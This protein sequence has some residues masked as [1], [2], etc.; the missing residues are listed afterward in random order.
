MLLTRLVFALSITALLSVC[1]AYRILGVFPFN[2]KSH[3]IVFEALMKGLAKR[4]HQVDVISHF[5]LKR[6][7]KNYNDII[8]LDGSMESL[9]NNYTIE[10]VS[11]FSSLLADVGIIAAEYGNRLCHFMGFEE[12]QKLIKNPPTD[13]PYDLVVTEVFGA[14]CYIGFGHVF[15]VPVV[16]ISSAIEYP[17][18]SS[19]IGNDDNPAY[20]PNVYH[21]GTGKMNFLGRLKTMVTNYAAISLFHYLTGESQTESMRKYL[22]P[23]ISHIRDVEKS[24]ALTL[25]NNNPVL[26]GV[27]PITPS[28]VQIA[29][30]HVEGNDQTLPLEL[31]SW[32]DESSHGVVYFTLGSMVLVESLPV[33]QI[34]EIFSSFK[35][36]APVK[37]LVKIVDSSKIPFKLPDNVKILPWTPQQPVL[38]HPNTKVF[39]T[40]GGLGG[41]QEA[42]YYGI[43]MIG[44]PLFGDQFRNVAAFAEKGML[45]RIDLKQLSEELL[46]SSLQTL[47]RNPAYKKKALHLSKL[48]REQPISPMNNAIYWIEYVIRNGADSIRSSALQFSWWQLAL[49]DVY[50]F[51]LSVIVLTL[52][53][54]VLCIKFIIRKF[55]RTPHYKRPQKRKIN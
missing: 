21:I 29:G 24:I 47:L 54:I 38:A 2:A 30:L 34:R 3:N 11:Q 39:I 7:L 25:V 40:H 17:W 20:V 5:P 41:I 33:D 10:F 1:S 4:G 15:K 46:D 43:P 51:I 23:D 37:V 53:A 44:I 36:I 18:I 16:A 42:L 52:T 26:S 35:K 55:S 27:K 31:K 6:P 12:M 28:L 9:M 45:I 48:F 50:C 22:S 8:N 19:F 49:L 13:P 14:H 32:M